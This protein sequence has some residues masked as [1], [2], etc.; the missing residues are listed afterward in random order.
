MRA[1]LRAVL[2]IPKRSVNPR[3]AVLV[4]AIVASS[5]ALA[6]TTP[7]KT[8]NLEQ[9]SLSPGG[10]HS[11]MLSTGDILAK[12]SIAALPGR[13]VPAQPPGLHSQR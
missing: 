9:V 6:Q 13:S 8:L 12:G 2:M 5:P 7:V 3:T 1:F 11:L 10:Q 4:G